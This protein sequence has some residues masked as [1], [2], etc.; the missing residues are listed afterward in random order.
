[1]A[2]YEKTKQEL[3]IEMREKREQRRQAKL[4][5][6]RRRCIAAAAAFSVLTSIVTGTVYNA[7]AKEITIT[8][9]N[10][11]EGKNESRKVRTRGASV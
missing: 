8:E 1:M 7:Y 3:L 9:I 11:F 10:E 6:R 5:L 4:K 2:T